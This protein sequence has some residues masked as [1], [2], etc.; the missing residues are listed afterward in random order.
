MDVDRRMPVVALRVWYLIPGPYGLD[1]YAVS[2]FM[3]VAQQVQ[4]SY[5]GSVNSPYRGSAIFILPRS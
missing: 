4:E 5:N 3:R 1:A 2:L